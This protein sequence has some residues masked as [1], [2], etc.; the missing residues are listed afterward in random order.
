[1]GNIK[2]E[3]VTKIYY[4]STQDKKLGTVAI[5]MKVTIDPD[6]GDTL[7]S[8]TNGINGNDHFKFQDSD[9][10]LIRAICELM[11]H[12]LELIDEK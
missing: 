11:Q 4:I 5:E 6:N 1:M 10:E 7:I 8:F 3:L 9:P 2:S 12:G